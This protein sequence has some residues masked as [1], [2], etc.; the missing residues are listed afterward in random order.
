M[1]VMREIREF[2]ATSGD[3]SVETAKLLKSLAGD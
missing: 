1:S 2:I 3:G